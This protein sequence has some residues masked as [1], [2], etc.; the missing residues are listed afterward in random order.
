M[1]VCDYKCIYISEHPGDSA[2]CCLVFSLHLDPTS[3]RSVCDPLTHFWVQKAPRQLL[4]LPA[5]G[6]HRLH[7]ASRKWLLMRE[8]ALSRMSGN[9]EAC[10]RCLVCSA[11]SS[12]RC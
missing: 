7:D 4:W 10:L 5:Y 8:E 11:S 12:T 9:I 2:K 3:Q 1:A 6:A